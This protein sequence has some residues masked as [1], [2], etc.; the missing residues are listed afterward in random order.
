KLVGELLP[1]VARP[2]REIRIEAMQA[3]SKVADESQADQVRRELQAQAGS[4]DQTISRLAAAAMNELDNR[5][6]G[7]A[8][9]APAVPAPPPPTA[10]PGGPRPPQAAAPDPTRTLLIND[11]ARRQ[12][13]AAATA[14]SRL[15]IQTLKPGDILEGRYKYI[16]RIGRGA[17]GT[18]LLM[19]DTVVDER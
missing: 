6:A 15:D 3:L 19:E 2:E 8:T 9:L 11:Q 10:A 7:V 18:V 4:Q 13:E 12:A 14:A 17:F 16:D 5:I 1:L